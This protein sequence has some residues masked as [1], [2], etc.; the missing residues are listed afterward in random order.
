MLRLVRHPWINS[1]RR[2][3]SRS[4]AFYYHESLSFIPSPYSPETEIKRYDAHF[5]LTILD[6]PVGASVSDS[7]DDALIHPYVEADGTETLEFNWV[8]PTQG[9]DKFASGQWEMVE[10]Q[11]CQ[12]SELE[13]R[14]PTLKD[15]KPYFEGKKR[16]RLE[17]LKNCPEF[18]LDDSRGKEE[19]V[20]VFTL[21]RLHTRTP[22]LTGMDPA[23]SQKE[24][25]QYRVVLDYDVEGTV[26]RMVFKGMEYVREVEG[27]GGSLASE[28]SSGS[29]GSVGRL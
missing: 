13:R 27:F 2:T 24:T 1:I 16:T 10:P 15:V 17:T 14:Y 6:H 18:Y 25:D 19:Q 4:S 11:F 22:S 28:R 29:P 3:V 9:L 7:E 12:L 20:L 23:V 5:F 26:Q 8:T 21:D